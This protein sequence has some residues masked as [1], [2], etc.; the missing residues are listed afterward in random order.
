MGREFRAVDG[1][2]TGCCFIRGRVGGFA[3]AGEGVDTIGGAG[4]GGR[5]GAT[6]GTLAGSGAS[7]MVSGKCVELLRA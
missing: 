6:L 3:D 7:A 4:R 1:A 5:G 2:I